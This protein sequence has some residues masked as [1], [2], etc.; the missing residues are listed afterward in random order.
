MRCLVKG[1]SSRSVYILW[2]CWS[3]WKTLRRSEPACPDLMIVHSFSYSYDSP[4][5]MSEANE[6][7]WNG[8]PTWLSWVSPIVLSG[9]VLQAHCQ[10][11]SFCTIRYV[12]ALFSK[13][14]VIFSITLSSSKAHSEAIYLSMFMYFSHSEWNMR[15][16]I[17]FDARTFGL[18]V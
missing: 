8:F 15:E 9:I 6:C 10:I 11:W 12:T 14:A 7:V 5:L 18:G 3:C 13:P 17:I 2:S 4:R 16:R 1:E